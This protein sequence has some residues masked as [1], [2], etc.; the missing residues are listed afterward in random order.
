MDL[1]RY[2]TTYSNSTEKQIIYSDKLNDETFPKHDNIKYEEVFQFRGNPVKILKMKVEYRYKWFTWLKWF[3][4]TKTFLLIQ[5][6][7]P[8]TKPL[9][10]STN[11][12]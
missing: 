10:N 6:V 1:I 8:N 5:Q 2:S 7:Y 4:E 9:P 12:W 11:A 3:F